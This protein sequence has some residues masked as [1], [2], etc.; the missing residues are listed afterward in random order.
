MIYGRRGGSGRLSFKCL[1]ALC[2]WCV[3]GLPAQL[4]VAERT[5][6]AVVERDTVVDLQSVDAAA[7]TQTRSAGG[8][9]LRISPLAQP[10]LI[11]H[12]CCQHCWH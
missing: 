10:V 11:L 4:D 12:L 6:A 5:G 1:T 7:L 8:C 9:R 2:M 3:A